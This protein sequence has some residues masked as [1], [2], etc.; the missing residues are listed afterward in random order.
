MC[1]GVRSICWHCFC[2]HFPLIFV[3]TRSS[4]YQFSLLNLT[5]ECFL[6]CFGLRYDYD[7]ITRN[8]H[9]IS[10]SEKRNKTFT[11]WETSN[12]IVRWYSW[13]HECCVKPVVCCFFSENGRNGVFYLRSKTI[14][15]YF[16]QWIQLWQPNEPIDW[17]IRQCDKCT[18][19]TAPFNEILSHVQDH[20]N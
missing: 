6:V 10:V 20:T 5:V 4:F 14:D 13:F 7:T 3:F 18:L 8:F 1:S 15:I 16:L 17:F 19:R 11:E 12:W 9:F 2:C